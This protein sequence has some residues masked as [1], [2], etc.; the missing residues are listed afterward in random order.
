MRAEAAAAAMLVVFTVTACSASEP[1]DDT[2]MQ[3]WMSQ[4]SRASDG[5]LGSMTAMASTME[6]VTAAERD[7]ELEGVRLDFTESLRVAAVEFSCFGSETMNARL[8]VMTGSSHVGLTEEDV[9]CAD[10]PVTIDLGS[11]G[12]QP[13]TGVSADGYNEHGSGAWSVTVR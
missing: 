11:I 6:A 5:G 9:R 2:A 1:P 4:Q 10:S 7:G 13:A 8:H 12:E 3:N